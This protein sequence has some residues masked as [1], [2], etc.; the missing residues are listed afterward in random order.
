MVINHFLLFG[1]KEKI[2]VTINK[3]NMCVDKQEVRNIFDDKFSSHEKMMNNMF[4]SQE[5]LMNE[6][7]IHS[8]KL[9]E[10]KFKTNYANVQG[11]F[12]ALNT[13]LDT[14]IAQEKKIDCLEKKMVSKRNV[15]LTATITIAIIGLLFHFMNLYPI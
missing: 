12:K 9:M 15:Y 2:M 8:E 10:E 3:K 4:S 1:M 7:F 5:K 11:D 6:K 14:L 13:R